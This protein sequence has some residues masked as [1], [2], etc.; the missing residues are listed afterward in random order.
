MAQ[1]ENLTVMF[2]DIVGY[3]EL[4]SKQSRD[5]NRAMLRDH[6]R[7]LLP[8]VA[9]FGG[10]RVK[11]IGDSLML[12]FRS[13]TDAVRCGMAMHDAL[14]E[15]NYRRPSLEQ[16]HIRVAINV[17]EVRVDG[18]DIFGE[19]VNVASRVEHMTPP[20][21]IYFT[22]AVYLAMNKAEVP[23]VLAGRHKLKGIPE[24]VKLFTVPPRQVNRL[25]PGGEELGDAPGELP[26]GGM[27][28]SAATVGPLAVLVNRVRSL[29]V[30][31]HSVWKE[32][33]VG[34]ALTLPPPVRLAPMLGALALS[35]FAL[36][37][38]LSRGEEIAEARMEPA[39]STLGASPSAATAP[40]FPPSIGDT[41][42]TPVVP[43]DSEAREWLDKGNKAFDRNR[44]R[45]AAPAYAKAL[46]L[47][48]SLQDDPVVATRVVACLS[49]ASD[50]AIPIIKKYPS[51]PM[52]DALAKRT[53]TARDL[54]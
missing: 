31:G 10:R 25:V 19:A 12:G 44:R 13:P 15:Y 46:E 49:W 35:A 29:P 23:S 17:G 22:E 51:A 41:P 52:I 6:N 39:S 14:A 33:L 21:Q 5:Q 4:T 50:L 45:E 27:H 9:R 42:T 7:I 28:R 48:P 26:Y 8:L 40:D 34:P 32:W 24:A 36:I 38:W 1:T 18:S 20:D 30:V 11:S 53:A 54:G 47:Q 43:K 2:T 3:T 37:W 16:I